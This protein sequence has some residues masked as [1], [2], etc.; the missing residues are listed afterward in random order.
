VKVT[1][2]YYAEPMEEK[3]SNKTLIIIIVVVVVLIVLCCCCVL[4]VLL[5]PSLLGPSVGNVFS[6]IIEELEMTP[7]P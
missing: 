2:D 1:E 5:V 6:N 4:G 7:M 3:K